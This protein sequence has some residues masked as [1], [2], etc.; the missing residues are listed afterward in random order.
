MNDL[1]FVVDNGNQKYKLGVKMEVYVENM[2]FGVFMIGLIFEVDV[3][4]QKQSLKFL[5]LVIIKKDGKVFLG[6]K[7]CG[8]GV[9]YFNGFGGKVEVNE[10]IDEV[11]VCEF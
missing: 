2:S 4:N 3:D 10:I 6:M 7:K 1:I 5:I 8:F 9:G 11:V